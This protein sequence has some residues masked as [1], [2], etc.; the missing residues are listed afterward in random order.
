MWGEPGVSGTLVRP[1]AISS[2]SIGGGG[3]NTMLKRLLLSAEDNG[4]PQITSQQGY[5]L[6][7]F[8]TTIVPPKMHRGYFDHGGAFLG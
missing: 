8:N 1:T 2:Q 4:S 6:K 5:S 3:H 7:I